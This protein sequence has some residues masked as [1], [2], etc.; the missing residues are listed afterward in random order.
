MIGGREGSSRAI[1]RKHSESFAN[2]APMCKTTQASKPMSQQKLLNATSLLSVFVLSTC[3]TGNSVDAGQTTDAKMKLPTQGV[4]ADRGAAATHPENTL[5]AFRQA[6]RLGCQMLAADVAQTSDGQLVLARNQTFQRFAKTEKTIADFTL[7]ELKEFPAGR[8][9]SRRFAKEKIPTVTDFLNAMPD[10]VAIWFRPDS[11]STSAKLKQLLTNPQIGWQCTISKPANLADVGQDVSKANTEW[12]R[13]PAFVLTENPEKLLTAA[14]DLGIT[15]LTAAFHPVPHK[16]KTVA[17]FKNG[18]TQVLKEFQS[19]SDWIIH[20]LWVE[21]EFDTDGDGKRDRMHVSVTRQRQTDTQDLKVPVVYNSSPYFS[22][23]AAGSTDFFWDPK[24]E[25]GSSPP[26]RKD[27][28]NIKQKIRR[29]QINSRHVNDWVPRGFAVVHSCSPG[30]GLSQGCPTIGADNESLAPKAVIQWLTGHAKGFTTPYGNEEV[31]AYWS[32]GKVGMTGT[33]FNGTLCL[34]AATTGVEGLKVI[35]PVAPNTSYYHYYR[36]N[37]LVRHPAGYMGEDI[38]ILYD[39][40][41]SGNPK[42]RDYCNCEVR[43]KQLMKEFERDSGDWNDFWAGRDYMNDLKPMK[44]AMLMSHAFNDWNVMPEHSVRIYQAVKEMGLPT[45]CYF[46]QGGHGGPP[47]I[48]MMN[49]WFTRYLYDIENGVENDPKSWVVRE[50]DDRQKPTSYADYPNPAAQHVTF[51]PTSST[52]QGGLLVHSTTATTDTATMTVQD[53][54]NVN[55]KTLATTKDSRHRLLFQTKE[56]QHPLHLSGTTKLKIRIAS[57]KPAANLSVWLVS[58]PWNN[59]SDAKIYDNIITRGWA[60]P[61]NHTSEVDGADLQPGKFYDIEF[62][63][64]PDDHIVPAGQKIGLM[65]FSSDKDFTLWPAPGTE[66]TVDINKT[67][68]MIPIVGG[69]QAA[70]AAIQ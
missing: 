46:H 26:E 36:S 44:A 20:D 32:T 10:N 40:V 6:I 66:L 9:K 59:A 68:L 54:Y 28:P 15:R 24:Q 43:D 52:K 7:A 64:Q 38:D 5:S 53:D 13:G 62:N 60:D 11:D 65:V 33:S 1:P 21:T 48:E 47:P 16:K 30:T 61:Q 39:Y 37:G 29:L 67:S 51:R 27:A 34:A 45:S 41:H 42:F 12:N 31:T 14:D 22:G 4:C 58:L 19:S 8:W 69:S 2:T 17:E 49:R 57:D 25:L 35:I 56:L 63:L 18:S 70:T 3:F 50:R 55:G 23:T